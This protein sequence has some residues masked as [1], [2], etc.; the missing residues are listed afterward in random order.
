[1]GGVDATA[2]C[3]RASAAATCGRGSTRRIGPGAD[4]EGGCGFCSS[5]S[6]VVLGSGGGEREE[7][8]ERR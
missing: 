2:G 8:R 5:F 6:L 7:V 3:D 1:M 4:G